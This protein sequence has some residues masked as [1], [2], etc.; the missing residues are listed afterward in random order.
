MLYDHTAIIKEFCIASA[1]AEEWQ[2][3]IDLVIHA[4]YAFPITVPDWKN[5]T[6]NE[7]PAIQ[8]TWQ[9]RQRFIEILLQRGWP[10]SAIYEQL[11]K[12]HETSLGYFL[13]MFEVR[14]AREKAAV[15]PR[16]P[17]RS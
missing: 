13:T 5:H 14:I 6:H 8:L 10:L 15:H 12:T 11:R 17:Q 7:V 3:A 16:E 4:G 2:A 9:G 1:S